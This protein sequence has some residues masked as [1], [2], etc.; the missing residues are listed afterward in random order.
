MIVIR[1]LRSDGKTGRLFA[2][3]NR[4]TK[5]PIFKYDSEVKFSDKE[6]IKEYSSHQYARRVAQKI[7]NKIGH[8]SVYL[9]N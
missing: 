5:T 7:E 2:G 6:N 3:F 4:K 8:G 9:T 1:K